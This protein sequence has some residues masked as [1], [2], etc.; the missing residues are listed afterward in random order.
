MPKLKIVKENIRA[1]I[2]QTLKKGGKDADRIL[3]YYN[4]R[5]PLEEWVQKEFNTSPFVETEIDF[6]P[7]GIVDIPGKKGLSDVENSK[8]IFLAL[9]INDSFATDARLWAGIAHGY[10]YDYLLDYFLNKGPITVDIV[11]GKFMFNSCSYRKLIE[12]NCISRLWYIGRFFY[13]SENQENP[14]YLLDYAS[15]DINGFLSRLMT[16]NI[17]NNPQ[18]TEL[19][20]R[21]LNDMLPRYG[22]KAKREHLNDVVAYLNCIAGTYCVD[23][24]P[25]ELL[26]EKLMTFLKENFASENSTTRT[27]SVE[28][29]IRVLNGA[30]GFVT[31]DK[32]NHLLRNDKTIGSSIGKKI[33]R[34]VKKEL[35]T[36][37][38]KYI[39]KIT[40][41]DVVYFSLTNNFATKELMNHKRKF[42]NDFISSLSGNTKIAHNILST[43][44]TASIKEE[45]LK[46]FLPHYKSVYGDDF[47]LE[48]VVNDGIKQLID[49]NIV[50]HRNG[51]YRYNLFSNNE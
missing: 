19:I 10:Y 4:N 51:L 22:I 1:S 49:A 14:F 30:N 7:T 26:Y 35:T 44:R 15:H 24:M 36:S 27:K 50:A 47:D 17:F 16:V 13:R 21:C 43:M 3:Q 2:C 40:I 25:T 39:E 29:T 12:P 20:I 32:F 5:I 45:E 37:T 48:A 38:S 34:F 31:M 33:K 9:D 41:D 8:A 46:N 11:L 6:S 23:V 18:M 28:E 42:I